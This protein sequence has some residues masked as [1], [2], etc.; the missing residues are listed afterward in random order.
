MYVVSRYRVVLRGQG[1]KIFSLVAKQCRDEGFLVEV[2]KS[3]KDRTGYEGA[4]VLKPKP[5]I[6]FEPVAVLDYASLY[7][8]SMIAENVSHDSIVC[9]KYYSVI[10]EKEFGDPETDIHGN[11]KKGELHHIIAGGEVYKSV[12]KY[13]EKYKYDN[14]EG[15]SF[16]EIEYNVY[17]DTRW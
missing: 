10:R 14:L 12:E 8:S 3:P 9:H 17:K 13:N 7:P 5:G 6:Y 2:V 15:Y 4:I 16:N 11:I 1:I